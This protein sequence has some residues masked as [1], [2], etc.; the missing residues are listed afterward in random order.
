MAKKILQHA[1][2]GSRAAILFYI[3]SYM[4]MMGKKLLM[5]KPRTPL[6]LMEKSRNSRL[7]KILQKRPKAKGVQ[8]PSRKLKRKRQLKVKASSM[9]ISLNVVAR[10][11]SA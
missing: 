9:S 1:K 11:F 2:L 7:V 3:E 10:R 6:G 5:V 4:E 8:H